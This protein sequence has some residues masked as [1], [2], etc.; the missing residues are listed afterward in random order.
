ME[1]GRVLTE[2]RVMMES[3]LMEDIWLESKGR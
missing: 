1:Y 2:E 3:V